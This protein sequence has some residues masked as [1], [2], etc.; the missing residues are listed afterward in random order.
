MQQMMQRLKMGNRQSM[1]MNPLMQAQMMNELKYRQL[2]EEERARN[3]E[4]EH[5]MEQLIDRIE[6]HTENNMKIKSKY[7]K[8]IETLMYQNSVLERE[9]EEL[10]L[11][12]NNDGILE[13]ELRMAEER[14]RGMENEVEILRVENG[15]VKMTLGREM[16]WEMEYGKE[17]GWESVIK[18][19]F[20]MV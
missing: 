13:N 9:V 16:F 15:T 6:R 8:E 5:K 1:G 17:L 10:R 19:G 3:E 12:G 4:L 20:L 7:S 11:E 2:Y 18:R 14:V